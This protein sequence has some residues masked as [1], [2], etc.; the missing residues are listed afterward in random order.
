MNPRPT[1]YKSVALPIELHQHVCIY[2][3]F[4]TFKIMSIPLKNPK[5]RARNFNK[6]RLV[7]FLFFGNI[8]LLRK[9][10]CGYS[11]VV[12]RDL[13]KVDAARSNRVTRFLDH[14]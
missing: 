1:D 9:K 4:N 14:Q 5:I 3:L 7:I 10:V 8:S 11:S 12:E 2:I 13:A 6:F